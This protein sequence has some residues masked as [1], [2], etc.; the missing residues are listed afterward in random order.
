MDTIKAVFSERSRALRA[1]FSDE[2]Y[3]L[4]QGAQRDYPNTPSMYLHVIEEHQNDRIHAALK[5]SRVRFDIFD[6]DCTIKDGIAYLK[7]GYGVDVGE[8][9][10]DLKDILF[11]I[12]EIERDRVAADAVLIKESPNSRLSQ[13]LIMGIQT[14]ANGQ[15]FS[16][17]RKSIGLSEYVGDN[18]YANRLQ[19]KSG[20]AMRALMSI[21][22]VKT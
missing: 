10:D 13:P 16:V 3:R 4:V 14:T 9:V 15:D 8:I 19:E 17:T 21:G 12:D 20:V 2:G 22:L 7:T 6:P 11:T 1:C 5:S 18:T